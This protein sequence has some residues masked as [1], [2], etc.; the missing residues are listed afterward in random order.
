MNTS[1]LCKMLIVM[2]TNQHLSMF[3]EVVVDNKHPA[4]DAVQRIMEAKAKA[5]KDDKPAK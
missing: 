1:Y 5:P 2:S 4:Y 3:E